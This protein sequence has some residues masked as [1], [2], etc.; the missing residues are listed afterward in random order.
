[1]RNLIWFE[2]W[3]SSS[4]SHRFR[5]LTRYCWRR[6]HQKSPREFDKKDVT[7][8]SRLKKLV[9]HLR[10][11]QIWRWLFQV[12]FFPLFSTSFMQLRFNSTYI[13]IITNYLKIVSFAN[14]LVICCF[15]YLS[16]LFG[17]IFKSEV[18]RMREKQLLYWNVKRCA[19]KSI[20]QLSSG[21]LGSKIGCVN[22]LAVL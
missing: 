14:I 9:W 7:F 19:R 8:I 12:R 22:K 20:R 2:N 15:V 13:T 5:D 11:R 4:L 18:Y 21:R 16:S 6:S 10:I 17:F 1:M 3:K